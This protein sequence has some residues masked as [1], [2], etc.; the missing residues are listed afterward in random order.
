[1]SS[2][3]ACVCAGAG[4]SEIP[5]MCLCVDCMPLQACGLL[6]LLS[7][8]ALDLGSVMQSYI[9]TYIHSFIISN[10]NY[11]YDHYLMLWL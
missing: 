5:S 9:H 11:Y 4:A 10:I 3:C 1:M 8:R 2:A 7:G 6:Y